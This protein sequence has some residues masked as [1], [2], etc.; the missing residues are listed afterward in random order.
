MTVFY[1]VA[2]A[3]MDPFIFASAHDSGYSDEPECF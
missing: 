3:V 1:R 2:T